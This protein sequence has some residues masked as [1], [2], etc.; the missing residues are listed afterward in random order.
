MT[1]QEAREVKEYTETVEDLM[2]GLSDKL[3]ALQE[4]N[5]NLRQQAVQKE[6][7]GVF[8]K[9][10]L[11]Q[12][13]DRMVEAGYLQGSEKN[14]AIEKL[15]SNPDSALK[16]L[17][18]LAQRTVKSMQKTASSTPVLGKGVDEETRN[19]GVDERESDKQFDSHFGNLAQRLASA[20]I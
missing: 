17:D 2:G 8:D 20:S 5:E 18:V 14:D 9:D 12:T 10:R 4:E 11:H 6:A 15:A 13:V 1:E 16:M 3:A 7:G 19:Q